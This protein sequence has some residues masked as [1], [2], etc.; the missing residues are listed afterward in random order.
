MTDFRAALVKARKTAF[1][2]E[3]HAWPEI[4]RF[5]EFL[6]VLEASGFKLVGPE[7][8][9]EMK[10]AARQSLRDGGLL[11]SY[12]DESKGPNPQPPILQALLGPAL[13]KAYAASPSIAERLAQ[14]EKE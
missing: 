5:I 2:H 10:A 11:P 6:Q 14:G 4:D 13:E 3:P 1:F 8:S 7:P 12:T 9:D